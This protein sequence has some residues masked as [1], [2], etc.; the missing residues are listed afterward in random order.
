MSSTPSTENTS[1]TGVQHRSA[2][3]PLRGRRG[4]RAM[5]CF[6]HEYLTITLLS[7]D[8]D[9]NPLASLRPFQTASSCCNVG[10]TAVK[11]RVAP[12]LTVSSGRLV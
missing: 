11:L 3:L 10:E 5:I 1:N 2:L 7:P 8:F 12:E 9:E 6:G 4:L